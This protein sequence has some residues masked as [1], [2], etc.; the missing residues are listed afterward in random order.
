MSHIGNDCNF[1]NMFSSKTQAV[2]FILRH[3]LFDCACWSGDSA[4]KTDRQTDRRTDR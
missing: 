1:L 3:P 4:V 2:F